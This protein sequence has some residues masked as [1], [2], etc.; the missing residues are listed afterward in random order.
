[1][2]GLAFRFFMSAALYVAVGMVLGIYMAASHDHTMAPVHAHLN[3]VGWASMGLFGLYY[4]N[5]PAAARSR[6]A[7]IHFWVSS[8]GLWL[9]VPGIALAVTEG[10]EGLA[11]GSSFIVLA[12]MLL[13]VF[14]VWS[15]RGAGRAAA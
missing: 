14:I 11:A 9:L 15:N 6:L 5:V 12:G 1:M 2:N 7:N 13:F 3:L 8:I 10:P 4:H